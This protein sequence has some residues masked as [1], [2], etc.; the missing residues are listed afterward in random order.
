[1]TIYSSTIVT[2]PPLSNLDRAGGFADAMRSPWYQL[3]SELQNIVLQTTVRYAAA[4]GLSGVFLPLTTRTV[5]CANALG[6]DSRP[7]QVSVSGVDTYLVDSMQF[8]LEYAC[9][10]GGNGCYTIMPSFRDD[11]PDG[12]HLA[13]FTHSEAELIGDLD[14]MIQ[15]VD[16]YVKALAK[17]ILE[18][19]GDRLAATRGDISHLQ[20]TADAPGSF[21]QLTFEEALRVVADV[22]GAVCRAGN[23]RS[24]SRKGE[25]ALLE[26][27][28]EM[29]WVRHF[30]YLSV[31]F[32]HAFNDRDCAF[33]RNADMYFGLGEIVGAG[34]R[35]ENADDLRHS[36]KIHGVTEAEYD[37]YVRMREEA[38]MKTSGFGMGV[39]RFLMWVLKH[40]DI[41]D[42]PLISRVGEPREWPATVARP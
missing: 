37:W 24:L 31:P 38:P 5:T 6:S 16:G 18:R 8:A 2:P 27:V 22:E 11:D 41:R 12:S 15:Y 3:I 19:L 21:E 13:Q 34:E 20:R 10:I 17:A 40:D 4:H 9:R 28:S 33:A 32:Y 25:A 35:H 30:D 42:M 36:M 23:H 14:V 26:R 39:D 1:V 7:V 29:L